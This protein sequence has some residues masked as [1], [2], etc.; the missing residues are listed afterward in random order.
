MPISYDNYL[1]LKYF[2]GLNG[3]RAIA[4]LM[5]ITRHMEDEYLFWMDGQSGVH[6][7]FVLSGYLITTLLLRE[8]AKHNGVSLKAFY[9]R[10][11]FRILPIYFFV[12][13]IY[14]FLIYGIP[15]EIFSS[16]REE[17]TIFLPYYLFYMN[18]FIPS[19]TG[20]GFAHSWSLGIEEKFYLFWP[21]IGFVALGFAHR[22]WRAALV[23]ALSIV[24]LTVTVTQRIQ[25]FSGYYF[26]AIGCLL[27]VLLHDKR[28][29]ERISVL[30]KGMLWP[31]LIVVGFT[32]VHIL[33]LD[34]GRLSYVYP[35][36]VALLIMLAVI[37]NGRL[38]KV[39]EISW[40]NYIGR[41]SY[42]VYLIHVL[43]I[44]AVQVVIEPGSGDFAT[45]TLIFLCS[46][47]LAVLLA[48]IM[49]A[50]IEKPLITHGRRLASQ[51]IR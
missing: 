11:T 7:F 9:I 3:L 36:M 48:S 17:F 46:A 14:V 20:A 49:Y 19:G 41:V 15:L 31:T 22:N 42:G 33:K 25:Y 30:A 13:G 47:A 27:G 32:V 35:I 38:T 16:K 28:W 34:Y 12:L 40:L 1:G 21:I 24:L 39:L 29:Y 23:I 4:A 26:L 2:S 45:I 18:E 51:I 8:E 10:R 44:N 43:A 50:V 37:G 5:V 6:I